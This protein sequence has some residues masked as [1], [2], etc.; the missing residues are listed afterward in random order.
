MMR[1]TSIALAAL[2]VCTAALAGCITTKKTIVNKKGIT[3]QLVSRRGDSVALNHPITIAPVRLYHILARIDIRLSVKEGQQRAPAFHLETLDVISQ[4]L[5]Q[6]LREAGPNQRVIV[7]SIRRE[8]RFGIFDTNYLTSFVAYAHGDYL[9]VHLSRSDWEIPPRKQ[10]RLPEPKIGKFPTKFRIL[11]GKA[12]K[13]VDEQSLAI[14]WSD[15]VFQRPS[16]TR[17]TPSGQMVR[18]TILMESNEPDS[19]EPEGDSGSDSRGARPID[20]QSI[21]AG[22]SPKILRELADL[23]EKRQRG[24][25]SEYDYEKQRNKILTPDPTPES[26]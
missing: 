9:F 4:G 26:N 11:P 5:A 23:E 6:G 16:R 8:K 13:M 25:I 21:P 12:M 3:V 2:V 1:R 7:Y 15:P 20:T 14:G 24:E 22:I 18:K 19:V 10:D 17:M